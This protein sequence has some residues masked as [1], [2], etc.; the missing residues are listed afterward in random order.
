MSGLLIFGIWL[1]ASI[2]AGAVGMRVVGLLPTCHGENSSC[3]RWGSSHY[4]M[5][6]CRRGCRRA[7]GVTNPVAIF[8]GM[9]LGLAWPIA[10]LPGLSL[11]IA[12]RLK[13][14]RRRSAPDEIARLER[15]LGVGR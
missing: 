14:E 3:Y 6:Y 2:P 11:L 5:A 13:V 7:R 9:A 4:C 1:L 15:E 12:L 10:L 8:G